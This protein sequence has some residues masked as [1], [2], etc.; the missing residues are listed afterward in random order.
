MTWE[1]PSSRVYIA[2]YFKN[3]N[4]LLGDKAVYHSF[5]RCGINKGLSKVAGKVSHSPLQWPRR[6]DVAKIL[7]KEIAPLS[8]CSS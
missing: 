8:Y 1:L 2:V 7:P 4:P 6:T 5:H 3:C